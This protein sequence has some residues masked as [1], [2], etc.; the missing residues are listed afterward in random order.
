LINKKSIFVG[1][2]NSSFH[3]ASPLK[4]LKN[5]SNTAKARTLGSTQGDAIRNITGS[6]AA[7]LR[8]SFGKGVFSTP[9]GTAVNNVGMSGNV[10]LED[11]NQTATFDASRV[12]PTSSE[13]RTVNV[14]Y[15]PR[16]H[17]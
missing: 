10:Y 1:L 3:R 6:L 11:Q 9:S 4:K 13:N 5:W 17:V 2:V 7:Y 15:P 16:I 14:A 12:V 8:M